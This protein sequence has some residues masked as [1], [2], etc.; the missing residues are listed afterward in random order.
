MEIFEIIPHVGIKPIKLGMKRDEVHEIFGMP[1]FASPDGTREGFFSGFMVDF[2]EDDIVE[3]I[4]I[5][6]S[7][8]FKGIFKGK[9]LLYMNFPRKRP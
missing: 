3:F 6:R 9:C 4:E 2:N 1:E 5:A 8:Q 7:G